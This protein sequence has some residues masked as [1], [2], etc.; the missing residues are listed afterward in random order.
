M[1]RFDFDARFPASCSLQLESL[2]E[3]QSFAAQ[4]AAA[5]RETNAV[6]LAIGLSGTL[7]AGKTQWTRFLAAALGAAPHEV[8][9]PTFVLIQ[10]YNTQPIIYHLDAY[11]VGD[12]DEML[13][14]GIEELLDE[15]ALTIIEWA[16][17]FPSIL[18]RDV[19]SIHW[20]FLESTDSNSVISI[21]T[22]SLRASGI[23]SRSV[24]DSL[25]SHSRE[26]DNCGQSTS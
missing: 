1:L 16:D 4:V 21:R 10:Q 7:G 3:C 26:I 11:R 14:L 20:D 15:P 13:D 5:I 25:R 2:D 19:L 12:E 9:S 24:L 6:P 17:R 18:P 22:V 23:R 8:S